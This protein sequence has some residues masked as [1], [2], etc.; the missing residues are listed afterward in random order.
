MT[1][2]LSTLGVGM[3][4]VGMRAVGNGFF[5]RFQLEFLPAWAK[6]ITNQIGLGRGRAS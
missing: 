2:V 1:I 6:G 5:D 3:E 4:A